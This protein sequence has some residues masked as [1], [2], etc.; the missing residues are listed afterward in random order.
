MTFGIAFTVELAEQFFI[1]HNT[2]RCLHDAPPLAWDWYVGT[3]GQQW[4]DRGIFEHSESYQLEPPAGPAGENLALGHEDALKATQAWYDEVEQWTPG[5]GFSS[6]TGHFTAM[7]WKGAKSFGCGVKTDSSRGGTL[8]VCRYKGDDEL[9]KNTPNMQGYF[10]EMVQERNPDKTEEACRQQTE[11]EW[12]KL[13]EA[14][15]GVPPSLSTFEQNMLSPLRTADACA[16][17]GVTPQTCVNLNLRLKKYRTTFEPLCASDDPPEK[18][19]GTLGEMC[20]LRCNLNGNDPEY[21][22]CPAGEKGLPTEPSEH[23][24]EEEWERIIG[25]I[26]RG[27]GKLRHIDLRQPAPLS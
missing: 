20:C 18:G 21:T 4:A 24:S 14:G 3:S 2:L 6:G 10:D 11:E 1:L 25:E 12:V 23:F 17:T 9:G 13:L 26:G 5:S 7:V 27:E 15:I 8:Y 19:C 22:E 16:G